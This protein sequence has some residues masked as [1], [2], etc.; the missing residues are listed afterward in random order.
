MTIAV[1][2][3]RVSCSATSTVFGANKDLLNPMTH[4]WPLTGYHCKGIVRSLLVVFVLKLDL[5]A[6]HLVH[7]TSPGPWFGPKKAEMK[8]PTLFIFHEVDD[9]DNWLS[10]PKRREFL[11]RLGSLSGPSSNPRKQTEWG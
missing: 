2:I 7:L 11:G 9:A 6:P 8:V 3:G 10:L 1:G 5:T 4:C